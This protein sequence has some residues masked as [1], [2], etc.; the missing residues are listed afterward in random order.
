MKDF[1]VPVTTKP[2]AIET[3]VNNILLAKSK[4]AKADV[5]KL[6]HQIDLLVY[7]LYELTQEEILVVESENGAEYHHIGKHY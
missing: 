2:E 5:S 1:P 3:L 4:D 7:Q 6:E